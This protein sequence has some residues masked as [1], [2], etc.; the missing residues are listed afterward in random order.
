MVLLNL[1]DINKI[2]EFEQLISKKYP[3]WPKR[4]TRIISIIRYIPN[5]SDYQ[6]RDIYFQVFGSSGGGSIYYALKE[7]LNLGLIDKEQQ[8]FKP[9]EKL[10]KNT[11]NLNEVQNSISDFGEVI[12]LNPVELIKH[13]KKTYNIDNRL[14]KEIKKSYDDNKKILKNTKKVFRQNDSEAELVHATLR[15]GVLIGEMLPSNKI[16]IQA[17]LEHNKI[18][19]LTNK[20]KSDFTT[21]GFRN[22]L[23]NIQW[24]E[25]YSI[26]EGITTQYGQSVLFIHPRWKSKE[27]LVIAVQPQGESGFSLDH[28]LNITPLRQLNNQ[29]KIEIET[30]FSNHIQVRNSLI[31][32]DVDGCILPF[33][34]GI[35]DNLSNKYI[36]FNSGSKYRSL[37]LRLVRKDTITNYPLQVNMVNNDIKNRFSLV[38]LLRK[39]DPIY[40]DNKI[41]EIINC[42]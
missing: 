5:L 40:L 22:V 20:K 23:D 12:L 11:L 33:T 39:Y 35:T 14:I 19:Q 42:T 37:G 13:I 17:E 8:Y 26:I 36:V 15:R 24:L 27:K 41:K 4:R 10:F 31:H 38:N 30:N 1:T 29:N 21:I 28:F 32:G 18:I 6:I 16:K 7:L 25:D 34:P 2:L 9:T 3:T